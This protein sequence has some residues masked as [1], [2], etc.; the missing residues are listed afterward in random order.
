VDARQAELAELLRVPRGEPRYREACVKAAK[1]AGQLGVLDFAL[2]E[3][4]APFLSAPPVGPDEV[5]AFYELGR[6]QRA[7]GA[8]HDARETLARLLQADPAHPGAAALLAELGTPTA[9]PAAVDFDALPD[10]PDAPPL[11]D[12]THLRTVRVTPGSGDEGPVFAVGALIA[13]RYRLEQRIGTGGMAVVFRAV[14]QDLGEE[15]AVKVFTQAVFDQQ[16]EERYKREL[17]LS[18]QISNPHVVRLFDIGSFRGLR[19]ITMELLRGE[20]LR[21]RMGSRLPARQAL[22]YLIQ[23]CDGLQAAHDVGVVHRDFKPENCFVTD[24]GRI[25][26]MDF[27]IAKV[28]S[29]P[30]ITTTGIIVGTPAYISPE[31]ISDFGSV[32]SGSDLYALGVVAYELF[33]GRLPFAHAEPLKLLMMHMNDAPVPPRA[34]E[35]GIPAELEGVILRLLEKRPAQRFASC[36]ELAARLEEIRAVLPS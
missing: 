17:R 18:R 15:I 4:F 28:Q 3:F 9:A 19:Y 2:E 35:P 22:D 34:H 27:G 32:G 16:T 12:P 21:A 8:P 1:L 6:L 13:D 29:A 14:D 31:Q 30:G 20:D 36:R 25:K 7:H 33:T 5:S 11:P 24:S 26:V 10:L 23:A